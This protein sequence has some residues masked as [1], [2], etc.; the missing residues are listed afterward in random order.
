MFHVL[1][2]ARSCARRTPRLSPTTLIQNYQGV[3]NVDGEV[4]SKK[5]RIRAP[6]C[7]LASG[8]SRLR[9]A[10]GRNCGAFGPS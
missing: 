2:P 6:S 3:A 4:G 8:A 9:Q 5:A 10:E 7:C 1:S